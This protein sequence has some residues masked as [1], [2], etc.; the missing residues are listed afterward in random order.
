MAYAIQWVRS[1]IFIIFM[2]AGMLVYSVAYFPW[3]VFSPHGAVAACHAYSR[4]VKWTAAWMVGLRC[5]VRGTPPTDQVLVAAKHQ[6]F[7]DIIMI[8]DAIPHGKFIMK[9][10]LLYAPLLGQYAYRL[11]SV[12]V[13][14]GKRGAAIAKMLADVKKGEALPG[15]LVIYSQGTRLAPGVKK[16]YKVG[17]AVLYEQMGVACYPVATNAGVFWPRHGIYRKPGVAVVE[18][19][20]PIPPGMEKDAFLAHLEEVVE[21][22]SDRL[23]VEAGWTPQ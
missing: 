10:I 7:L 16:P 18:F 23:L 19:L 21:A 20:E 13:N 5:E 17:T 4:Y 9:A 3:T 11:G 6:S 8:F 15:Q 12:P 2:Y 22:A 14:R 1:L